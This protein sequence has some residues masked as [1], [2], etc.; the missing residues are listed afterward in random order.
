[1]RQ[2]RR[3]TRKCGYGDEKNGMLITDVQQLPQEQQQHADQMAL[4]IKS[5][6]KGLRISYRTDRMQCK[7]RAACSEPS[8][9]SWRRIEKIVNVSRIC[10]RMMAFP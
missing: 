8:P 1:M 10:I 9:F 4:C 7:C 2:Q 3:R 5:S 6:F